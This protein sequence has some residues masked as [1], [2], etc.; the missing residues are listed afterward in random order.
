MWPRTW[1]WTKTWPRTWTWLL[2]LPIPLPKNSV[3]YPRKDRR[4]K[5]RIEGSKKGSKDPRKDP[6]IQKRIQGY[7]DPF[8]L[9]PIILRINFDGINN[10]GTNNHSSSYMIID[11]I[12]RHFIIIFIIHQYQLLNSPIKSVSQGYRS[13]SYYIAVYSSDD[14][15][16][17]ENGGNLLLCDDVINGKSGA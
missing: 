9:S 1:T 6:R 5:E 8:D 16:N 11:C 3:V 14:L 13:S 10:D 7:K 15:I 2:P 12:S 17:G 4:I